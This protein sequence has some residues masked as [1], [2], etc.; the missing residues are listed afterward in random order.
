[1]AGQQTYDE[2][3]RRALD[4]A[5]L[6]LPSGDVPVGAV[7]LAADGTTLGPGPQRRARPTATRQATR[8]YAHC[9]AAAELPASGG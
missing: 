9:A 4:E 6:A 5:A 2:W 8:R 3:M 7:V 1:M